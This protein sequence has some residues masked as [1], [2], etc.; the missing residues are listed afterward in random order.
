MLAW[1]KGKFNKRFN[2]HFQI[3]HSWY[4]ASSAIMESLLT[5]E[6]V[7]M[8]NLIVTPSRPCHMAILIWCSILLGTE[9]Q[10]YYSGCVFLQCKLYTSCVLYT[11]WNVQKFSYPPIT[12]TPFEGNLFLLLSPN[13]M[14]L[15]SK[16]LMK[17][18]IWDAK[19]HVGERNFILLD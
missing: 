19:C 16:L 2:R 7:D 14:S 4:L 12:P 8:L 1:S 18:I 3:F 17:Y 5:K 9:L 13:P 15:N 10:E 11:W 6:Q